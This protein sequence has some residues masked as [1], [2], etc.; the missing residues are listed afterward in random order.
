MSVTDKKKEV[1]PF[2]GYSSNSSIVGYSIASII[3]F[4]AFGNMFYMKGFRNRMNAH[5]GRQMERTV[6][7]VLHPEKYVMSSSSSSRGA[8]VRAAA[9][10]SAV[11]DE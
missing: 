1:S 11:V 8:A 5:S 3:L 4:T 2:S 6:D 7:V 10:A 9:S